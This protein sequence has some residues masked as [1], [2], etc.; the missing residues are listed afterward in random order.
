MNIK[1]Y[2]ICVF[3]FYASKSI[4]AFGERLLETRPLTPSEI[5][6][7]SAT[8]DDENPQQYKLFWKRVG[9][10]EIQFEAHCRTTGWVGFGLSH[11]GGMTGADIAIGWVKDGVGY[12]KDTHATGFSRPIED[13]IQDF[14]LIDSAEIDG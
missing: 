10:D 13:K 9:D 2:L 6:T 3:I 7:H 1:F 14:F 4:D 11:T 5:Y 12:L 8:P